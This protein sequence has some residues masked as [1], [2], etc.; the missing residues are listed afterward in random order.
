MPIQQR[1]VA[2]NRRLGARYIAPLSRFTYPSFRAN[3][4]AIVL[5]PAPAGPSIAIISLL[6]EVCP[7][8][9]SFITK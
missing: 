9:W 3:R 2:P 7:M 6:G 8:E 4:E 5:L 1:A